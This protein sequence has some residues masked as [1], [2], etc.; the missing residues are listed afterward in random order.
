M[1]VRF[2]RRAH[3]ENALSAFIDFF[4]AEASFARS[5]SG[6]TSSMRREATDADDLVV[7][8]HLAELLNPGYVTVIFMPH[9]VHPADIGHPQLKATW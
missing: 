8:Q 3:F 9:R 4:P 1:A 7:D 2:C 5:S 6:L